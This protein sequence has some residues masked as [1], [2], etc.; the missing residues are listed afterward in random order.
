MG[1]PRTNGNR[2]LARACD[3]LASYAAAVWPRFEC[4]PHHRLLCDELEDVERADIDRL[5][6]A[7]PPRHGKSLLTS[8]IFPAW[9]LGRNPTWSII[10]ASYGQELANDFGRMVRGFIESNI[11]RAIFPNSRITEDN[12]AAHR[13]GLQGG[14]AYF[15]A[16]VGGP[17]T[18]R[19]ADLLIIDDPQ[20][21]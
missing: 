21:N 19:G 7:E 1:I 14:G 6:I 5:Q 8:A 10:A 13:F 3:D 16:G 20:K 18:G 12:A 4:A 11:H 15:A 17:I 2:I 9:V